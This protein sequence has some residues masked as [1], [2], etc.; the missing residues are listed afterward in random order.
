[1]GD[2]FSSTVE[3]L[4]EA[5]FVLHELEKG[6]VEITNVGIVIHRTV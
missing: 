3:R 1:M 5:G 6:G 4:E 2:T